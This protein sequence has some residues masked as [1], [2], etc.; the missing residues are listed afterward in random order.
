[1]TEADELV[2]L[3]DK[4]RDWMP[5]QRNLLTFIAHERRLIET[6][7]RHLAEAGTQTEPV[8]W[9]IPGDDNARDNGA[10]DAMA[11]REGEFTKPLYDA[12]PAIGP[13][14]TAPSAGWTS[15]HGKRKERAMSERTAAKSEQGYAVVADGKILVWTVSDTAEG[16]MVAWLREE[17]KVTVSL[18]ATDEVVGG[19]FARL[20]DDSVRLHRVRIQD[21]WVRRDDRDDAREALA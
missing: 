13:T 3:A 11:W 1:M 19:I 16:A 7:L 2:K 10:I 18:S 17:R 6:A 14:R 4:V 5:S 15:D 21:M 8:A 12:P 20:A 9:V